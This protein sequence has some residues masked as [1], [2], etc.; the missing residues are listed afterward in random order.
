MIIA[1]VIAQAP[2]PFWHWPALYDASENLV[3]KRGV[4]R[5]GMLNGKVYF[6][7]GWGGCLAMFETEWP[8]FLESIRETRYINVRSHAESRHQSEGWS[9]DDWYN[10][11]SAPLEVKP[12]WRGSRPT[13]EFAV[14]DELGY[15]MKGRKTQYRIESRNP[16]TATCTQHNARKSNGDAS[17]YYRLSGAAEVYDSSSTYQVGD[18]LGGM[19]VTVCREQDVS[20][21]DHRW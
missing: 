4:D 18:L 15:W 5:D 11:P 13:Y 19:L 14:D 20:V 7:I 17:N 6:R 2:A 12:Y 1:P 16:A 21:E 3:A 8:D 9:R 10:C